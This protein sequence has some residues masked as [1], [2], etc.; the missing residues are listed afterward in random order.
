MDPPK[1]YFRRGRARVGLVF[2]CE[3]KEDLIMSMDKLQKQE[4]EKGN[5]QKDNTHPG[6]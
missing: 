4:H 2:Y 3:A 1:F 6:E 5:K